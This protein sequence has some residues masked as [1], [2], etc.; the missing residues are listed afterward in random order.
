MCSA[1]AEDTQEAVAV[2]AA[3][4]T[5]DAP[6]R[7]VSAAMTSARHAL[8]IALG[9]AA[10]AGDARADPPRWQICTM[11]LPGRAGSPPYYRDCRPLPAACEATPTCACLARTMGTTFL[12]ACNRRGRRF[13]RRIVALP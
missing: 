7:Y 5:R 3:R 6:S 8:F 9:C 1:S 2:S 11:L 13:I 4:V 12:Y 10:L